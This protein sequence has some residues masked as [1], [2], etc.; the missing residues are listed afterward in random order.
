MY[1]QL[2]CSI[3]LQDWP[4]VDHEVVSCSK[5]CSIA[6]LSVLVIAVAFDMVQHHRAGVF[7]DSQ[8]LLQRLYVDQQ[9]SALLLK[10]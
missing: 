6:W 7:P 2:M 4:D 1:A 10:S 3:M 8:V 5:V 9:H